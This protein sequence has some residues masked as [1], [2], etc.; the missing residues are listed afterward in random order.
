MPQQ[1]GSS[2]ENNFTK[3][4]ITEATGL[5][6][7]ENAA[8]DCE[9]VR[10]SHIGEVFR[11]EGINLEE[12][13][14]EYFIDTTNGAL[15][16]YKWDNAGGTGENQLMVVQVGN[17]L[18]FYSVTA[19]TATVPLSANRINSTV[20]LNTLTS[21][22]AVADS[23]RECDYTAG[24]GYL[25]V[26]HPNCDPFY[27]T[28]VSGEVT[29]TPITVR[30][31]DFGG[32]PESIPVNSRPV[33]LSAVHN[34]NLTNQGWTAG[35]PWS[36]TTDLRPIAVGSN[37]FVVT[38]VAGVTLGDTVNMFSVEQLRV[39]G[40][41]QFG[42]IYGTGYI[43]AGG[44]VTAYAGT[45]MTI[46]IT[47]INLPAQASGG[48]FAYTVTKTNSGFINTWNS[49]Q[50]NYPSN[51]DVWWYFKDNTGVFNP[52]TTQPNVTLATGNAPQ[53]HYI[54][55]A[56][57]IDRT[58]A[59]GI[60]S[61]ATVATSNRPST[62]TWFQGRVWY[63][64]MQAAAPVTSTSPFYSWTENV[65]FSQI[66]V[67]SDANFGNCFQVND[68]TS[69][70]L[71]DLLPTDGGV[72]PIQGSG[73]INKLFPVQN[74]MLVFAANGIWFITGSQGIGF[75]ANDYTVTKISNIQ[76]ISK[77]SFVDVLGMPFWW[78]EEG[79][80]TVQPQQ[81]GSLAAQNITEKTIDR[82]YADIPKASKR[83][84][85]G[86]Y[87]PIDREIQ[88]V[89][90]STNE[91]GVNDRYRMDRIMNFATDIQSFFP[92]SIDNSN[93]YVASVDYVEG[94]GGSSSADPTFKYFCVTDFNVSF[95]EERDHNYVDWASKEEQDYE[96][97]FV[98]GYKLRGKGVTKFS[99]QYFRLYI[100]TNSEPFGY[101][102]QGLWDYANSGNSGRWSSKQTVLRNVSR[103]DVMSYR[104]KVRGH[105]VALQYKVNS[106]SGMPFNIIGW[107]AVDTI[108]QGT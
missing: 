83:Y 104:H 67:G 87:N 81:G 100:N 42:Y 78:N 41:P 1:V 77:N 99:N 106:I 108:E 105:G 85:K 93:T 86:A 39:P 55:P 3:G 59:S 70:N 14:Q 89:Y 82:F 57:N 47:S 34:Y 10:Y 65:Y 40:Q 28:Y 97:F 49:S 61:L 60:A 15:T 26:F 107:T 71:F 13:Y 50:G 8:T 20:D 4:L 7:P 91:T 2:A 36:T 95:A 58:A 19:A 6:F 53:G 94:P 88:W 27:C 101:Q 51:A 74:G 9:N 69:E 103:Y 68:P 30:I 37:A 54:V 25:F 11:R 96:S 38:A 29:A 84:A 22:G 73:K 12:N 75:A 21:F 46:N 64:G 32:I 5:N 23:S 90:R 17:T 33:S 92:F 66:N 43:Q 35:S 31:R 44:T 24:N 52:A 62:G 63:T 98:T 16:T 79:I 56:F 45:N 80:F 18:L 48:S 76:S 102:L 72:I